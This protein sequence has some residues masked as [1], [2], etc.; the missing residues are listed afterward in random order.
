MTKSFIIWILVF[1]LI[2][3]D[4]N[5]ALTEEIWSVSLVKSKPEGDISNSGEMSIFRDKT[6]EIGFSMQ[7]FDRGFLPEVTITNLSEDTLVIDWNTASFVDPAGKVHRI[8]YEGV[9]YIKAT[10][11]IP[12]VTLAPNSRFKTIIAPADLI[13]YNTLINDW[14]IDSPFKGYKNPSFTL[15]LPIKKVGETTY[16]VLDYQI[17]V[18]GKVVPP[19]KPKTLKEK[20]LHLGIDT[21]P[22]GLYTSL[23]EE[24]EPDTLIGLSLNL[25]IFPGIGYRKYFKIDKEFFA[26]GELGTVLILPYLGLGVIYA[27]KNGIE[28][29]LGLNLYP[30]ADENG[31]FYLMS[32]PNFIIGAR[33]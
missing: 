4:V 26:Y 20:T 11:E 16:Y 19:P 15:V 17:T 6:V 23:S 28:M 25:L 3:L 18:T 13:S 5:P 33:F 8:V 27:D 1:S 14:R 24:G 2:W 30:D 7:F 31:N 10:E 12:P 22:L 29:G 32:F 21:I 9:K